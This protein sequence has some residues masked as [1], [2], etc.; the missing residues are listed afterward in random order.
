MDHGKAF[1]LVYSITSRNSFE[2]IASFREHI[3]RVKDATDVP[4]VL[5]GNKCDLEDAREVNTEEGKNLARSFNCP[6]F[7]TSAATRLNIDKCFQDVVREYVKRQNASGA[8]PEKK[9][10][11]CALL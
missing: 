7:E 2:E 10:G 11:G 4:I 3:L 8:K 9:K 1:L 6:F 5:V